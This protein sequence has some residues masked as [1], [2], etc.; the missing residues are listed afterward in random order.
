MAGGLAANRLAEG[1]LHDGAVAGI[2]RPVELRR[3]V[4]VGSSRFD[5]RVRP[6]RGRPILV[7][8]KS[9]TLVEGGVARFPDAPSERATRHVRE[10]AAHARAGGRAAI[11]FV[12]QRGDACRVEPHRG[13]DPAFAEALADA[14]RAGVRLRAAAFRLTAGGQAIPAGPLPVRT[15]A[16]AG[17]TPRSP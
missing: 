11:L 10:L 17:L 9:V 7:E 12:V 5:F 3:E 2:G 15:S 4:R 1:L 14:R 13:I 16:R 8:V 6:R